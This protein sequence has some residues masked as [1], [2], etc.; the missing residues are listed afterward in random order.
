MK[1]FTVS[2]ISALLISFTIVNTH[3][4]PLYSAETQNT[5]PPIQN[6]EPTYSAVSDTDADAPAANTEAKPDANTETEAEAGTEASA[7][8]ETNT[9]TS[10][11]EN[12][13]SNT[14]ENGQTDTSAD[15]LPANIPE[16]I[17]A[18]PG[19]EPSKEWK[20]AKALLDS[21][22]ISPLETKVLRCGYQP[23][24]AAFQI[25][26]ETGEM[27]G[28]SYDI[29]RQIAHK[30]GMTIEWVEA[31][32]DQSP[33]EDIQQ[34][35]YDALCSGSCIGTSANIQ[36][37]LYSQ[38]FMHVPLY[39]ISKDT[40]PENDGADIHIT[41]PPESIVGDL[42]AIKN[43]RYEN[44]QSA[45]FTPSPDALADVDTDRFDAAIES[46]YNL[47]CYNKSHDS[48]PLKAQRN[49]FTF[50]GMSFILP[51]GD[52]ALKYII[53]NHLFNLSQD[54]T[55]NK[56]IR[57]Y[58]PQDTLHWHEAFITYTDMKSVEL[59]TSNGSGQSCPYAQKMQKLLQ[60]NSQSIIENIEDNPA[61]PQY[62][63]APNSAAGQDDRQGQNGQKP[64]EQKRD[65]H[66]LDEHW[67]ENLAADILSRTPET[68]TETDAPETSQ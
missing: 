31:S 46:Y 61:T 45:Q 8:T 35:R 49:P 16:Q 19:A 6:T 24:S 58:M 4:T 41:H 44:L 2:L 12:T 59:P 27:S 64:A 26:E 22:P 42:G 21:A 29:I 7:D 37:T 13:G 67:A 62:T 33:S 38:A 68:L 1:N 43:S 66:T 3:V 54:G 14:G 40:L 65:E 50:C 56:T 28:Y 32:T 30:L 11:G 15:S 20:E 17:Q 51:A 5:T 63:P 55:L 39:V 23:W 52:H 10:T 57:D 25:N 36:A 53:D 9:D 60:E 48:A 18:D 34:D 47:E